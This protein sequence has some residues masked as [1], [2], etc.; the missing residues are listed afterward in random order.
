MSNATQ[1]CSCDPLMSSAMVNVDHET[2]HDLLLA[3]S[4]NFS[5]RSN[6]VGYSTNFGHQF[7]S[8]LRPIGASGAV[9]DGQLMMMMMMMI[10]TSIAHGSI[11]LNVQC[12]EGDY[13][14]K[15]DRK[16]LWKAE[17][18]RCRVSPAETEKETSIR[19]QVSF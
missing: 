8:V 12:A 16:S 4:T 18:F 13:R 9:F 1:R 6:S 3:Y 19:K 10:A 15:M 17:K 14:E 7:N 5:H 11:D 2:L